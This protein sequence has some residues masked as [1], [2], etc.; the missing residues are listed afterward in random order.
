MTPEKK[1]HRPYIFCHLH[2]EHT[3]KTYSLKLHVVVCDKIAVP[4]DWVKCLTNS[5]SVVK[6]INRITSKYKK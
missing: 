6:K 4:P 3:L 2:Q 5:L 1:N